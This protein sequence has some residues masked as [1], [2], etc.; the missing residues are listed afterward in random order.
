MNQRV[1]SAISAM[2]QGDVSASRWLNEFST[3]N[4]AWS[5]AMALTKDAPTREVQFYASN[6]LYAK[7]RREMRLLKPHVAMELLRAVDSTFLTCGASRDWTATNRSDRLKSTAFL[8]RLSLARA[9]AAAIM[10]ERTN[11]KSLFDLMEKC[12]RMTQGPQWY[13]GVLGLTALPNELTAAGIASSTMLARD[14]SK[15]ASAFAALLRRK[16][17]L[18]MYGSEIL[19]CVKA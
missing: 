11:G 10:S 4:E 7:I 15:V 14:R 3:K 5:V 18:R 2:Y 12:V 16:D 17:I 1:I 6:M 8:R 13:V 19:A 9:R